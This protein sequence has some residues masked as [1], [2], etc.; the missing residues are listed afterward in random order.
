MDRKK[1]KKLVESQ[2]FHWFI[3]IVIAIDGIAIGAQTFV[4]PEW[5]EQTLHIIDV[6]CLCIYILE[7]L[8]KMYAW[9]GQYFKDG[10]NRF[11]FI[12][13]ILSLIP[14]NLLPIPVQVARV[15]RLFR[16]GRVFK[17]VS[18]FKQL[19]VIVEAIG[20]SMAGVAWAA[21]LLMLVMYVFNVA[22]VNMFGEDFPEYFGSLGTGFLTLFELLTL[23]G[24]NE[25]A[26]NIMALYPAAWLFFIPY[27]IISAFIMINVVTGIIINAVDESTQ[28]E[29]INNYEEKESQLATELRELKEQVETVQYLL[30]KK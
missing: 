11:D 18:A 2:Q 3:I 6:I 9:R 22:G 25:I 7:M 14:H 26:H 17:L 30:S 13:I 29:R 8:L 19:R 24:W 10:W 4:L 16:I 1:V 21:L 20:R 12:I 15:I 28:M 5:L 27:I 23:E